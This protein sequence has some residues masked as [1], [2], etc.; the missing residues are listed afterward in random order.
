M[1][2]LALMLVVA[3]VLSSCAAADFGPVDHGCAANPAR[4]QGSGCDDGGDGGGGNGGM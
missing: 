1:R 4:A 3:A 2:H